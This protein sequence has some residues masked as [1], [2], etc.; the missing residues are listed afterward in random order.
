MNKNTIIFDTKHLHKNLKGCAVRSGAVTMASQAVQFVFQLGSTMILARL[1]TPGD[2][3]LVAMVVALANFAALFKDL[4]LSMATIQRAEIN[5]D[6]VSALFW[7]NV[8][9]SLLTTIV[10]VASAPLITFFYRDPR[11]LSITLIL[12]STFLLG[13]LAVQHQALLQRQMKFKQLAVIQIMSSLFSIFTAIILAW[14]WRDTNHAYMALVWMQVIRALVLVLGLWALCP[15]RPCVPKRAQG[16]RSM[17]GYGVHVTGFDFM[18]YWARNLDRIL[19]GRYLGSVQLGLY[20]KAY[21]LLILPI[22]QLRT[23][24]FSVAIPVLSSLQNDSDGY[25]RYMHRLISILAFLSMP[26]MAYAFVYV[27]HIIELL[28]GSQWADAAPI[29]RILALAA[30]IQPVASTRGLA[31]LT[32]GFSQRYIIFGAVNALCMILAFIVGVQWETTGIAIAYSVSIYL[33]LFPTLYY[34]YKGTPLSINLF[35]RAI[36]RPVVSSIIL[37]LVLTITYNFFDQILFLWGIILVTI[38]FSVG[39]YLMTFILLPLGKK[40]LFSY[41]G[42]IR[43]LR[44]NDIDTEQSPCKERKE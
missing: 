23:P 41:M 40:E 18:N 4:G 19:I 10:V 8:G 37:A 38:V 11:L 21:Q 2:F 22:N 20:S 26:M 42:Y 12:A 9:I 39:V 32:L 5:H 29:F 14:M 16:V 24:I 28:L 3:G 30:F 25:R 31:L 27:R 44:K 1:L 7:V 36:Y 34:C 17:L 15:W 13:G 33:L 43:H 6:Q 35:L